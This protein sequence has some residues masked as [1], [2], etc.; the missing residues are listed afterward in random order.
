[1]LCENCTKGFQLT[2]TPEGTMQPDGSYFHPRPA[3][4]DAPA[5]S[6]V[7][8]LTD[9]FGL[10]LNN[11]KVM[12]DELSKSLG[13]DVWVPDMFN[14]KPLLKADDLTPYTSPVPGKKYSIWNR[15][16]LVFTLLPKVPG[17]YRIRAAVVDKL[18]ADFI[19]KLKKERGYTTIGV[20]G[21]CFGGN[22]ALRLSGTDLIQGAV[23]AHPG[24][25][26][27]AQVNAIKAPT[28]WLCAEED[29]AF[30]PAARKAA[31]EAL[32]ARKGG[33]AYEFVDYEGTTH[34][35][36]ARPA[37]EH[38]TVKDAFE[39]SF[40]KTIEFLGEVVKGKA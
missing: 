2:G 26:P 34:G 31:E 32:A 27:I 7:L 8:L 25:A 39:K 9:V 11:P 33:P 22:V 14:G 23:I 29:E 24:G 4:S 28:V 30:G 17:F 21:Y 38:P 16:S 3:D 36:A 5:T 18:V 20:T 6:A 35:F 13:V 12:A 19:E 37:L 15:V 1:M 40:A 10:E